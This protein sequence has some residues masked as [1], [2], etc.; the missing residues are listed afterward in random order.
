MQLSRYSATET[1]LPFLISCSTYLRPSN[2]HV[3]GFKGLIFNKTLC[4]TK[5]AYSL[6]SECGKGLMWGKKKIT[7]K[8]TTDVEGVRC[9]IAQA[10]LTPFKSCNFPNFQQLR[11]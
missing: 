8:T 7:L 5:A 10:F 11:K 6:S 2:F 3:K 9:N 1:F 4:L